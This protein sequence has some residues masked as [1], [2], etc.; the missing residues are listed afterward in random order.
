MEVPAN[1]PAARRCR[2]AS[3]AALLPGLVIGLGIVRGLA[4]VLRGVGLA[5]LRAMLALWRVGRCSRGGGPAGGAPAWA[6]LQAACWP[7]RLHAA[8]CLQGAGRSRQTVLRTCG[9]RHKC[10]KVRM[11]S[12]HLGRPWTACVA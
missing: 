2:L 8:A 11:H 10:L 5:F 3:R 4:M 7:G 9:A 6:C 1:S 12:T